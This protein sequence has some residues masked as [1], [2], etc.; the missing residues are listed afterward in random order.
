MTE[1][2]EEVDEEDDEEDE[3][4]KDDKD[5][6]KLAWRPPSRKHAGGLSETHIFQRYSGAPLCEQT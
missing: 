5:K 3:D 1:D 6:T 4:N 2:D